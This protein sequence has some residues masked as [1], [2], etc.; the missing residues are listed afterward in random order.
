MANEKFSDLHGA[1]LVH[2]PAG[3]SS[4]GVIE[5]LQRI[6]MHKHGIKRRD[7]PKIGHGGTLDP[8]ATGLLIVCIGRG[9][10]L[11]RYFLGSTKGY[12]GTI[13][14]GE[15]SVAGDPTDP[16]SE[17]SEVVPGSVDPIRAAALAMTQA[18]YLQT[19]PM[20]SAKKKDGK[21]L[22]ELA[23][24]GIEIE[25]EPKLCT[26]YQ[27]DIPRYE[28]PHASFHVICSSGTYIR[29][30]AKDLAAKLGTVALLETLHRFRSGI[31]TI[32]RAQSLD[33]IR[34]ATE[35]GTAWSKMPC[36]VPF[37]QLLDGNDRAQASEPEALALFQ[38]RQ[39][40]LPDILS[41]TQ[42]SP[43]AYAKSDTCVAIYQEQNLIAIARQDHGVWGLERVFLP[44]DV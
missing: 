27:F 21:P 43:H 32:E 11:A 38:G 18:P 1:L 3:I 17:T 2:K 10:K 20:H 14:F 6:L 7:L 40:V 44:S 8:F 16:I 36:W 28:K 25:R 37:D 35:A 12:E 15:T 5:E 34:Q 30:L 26:L 13:R 41:R 33:E 22:Y 23:R 24:Q 39:G 19:P 29:V 42:S 4:F 31:F 9:V